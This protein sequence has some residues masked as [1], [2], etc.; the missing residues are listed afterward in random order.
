MRRGT[1]APETGRPSSRPSRTALATS[2]RRA[3]RVFRAARVRAPAARPSAVRSCQRSR[4]CRHRRSAPPM[5][6][7]GCAA[8]G[9]LVRLV[10]GYGAVEHQ[11]Q[12]D[13]RRGVDQLGRLIRLVRRR[14][15]GAGTAVVD[16]VAELVG[17]QS[18]RRR[19]VDQPG[20]LA[21]P[22]DLHEARMVLET[23][24]DMVTRLQADR[25][26][27]PAQPIGGGVELGERLRPSGLGDHDR[28][29]VR[30]PSCVG[31]WVHRRARYWTAAPV[32]IR[33]ERR[34]RRRRGGFGV[35]GTGVVL[36]VAARELDVGVQS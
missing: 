33:G 23:E 1:S 34:R 6:P 30:I 32:P 8:G 36:A 16:D 26:Q 28:R 10:A 20:V 27:Q 4:A 14:D 29:F 24:R 18:R 35:G 9:Q 21:A 2:P 11:A 31:T 25:A 13:A 3:F 15:E 12:L 7:S 5:A 22:H 19:G 17:R